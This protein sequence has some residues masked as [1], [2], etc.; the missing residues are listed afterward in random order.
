MLIIDTHCDSID[1]VKD[2][3]GCIANPYNMSAE[4]IQFAAMFTDRPGLAPEESWRLLT[5]MRQDLHRQ[6]QRWPEKLAFC[7]TLGEADAAV[8]AGKKALFFSMEGAA[9]LDGRPERLDEVTADGLR[10]VA[11]TWNQNNRYG[12]ANPFSGTPEDTG[13]T[14][15]GI[16]LVK[17]L[18]RRGILTDVSHASDNTCLDILRYSTLPVLATHSDFR[19]VTDHKR[20]LTDEQAKAIRDTGGVIG[21]NLCLAFLGDKG[22]DALLRHLEYGLR[23][24]GEDAIGF[25]FDI[26][27]IDDYPE[28]LDLSR[29]IHEQVVE[30]LHRAGYGEALIEKLACGNFRRVLAQI[31][32]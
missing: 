21:L 15:E 14:V 25:G 23:L 1:T 32:P 13:L 17:E 24:V 22:P 3:V 30:L 9:A 8:A 19:A 4:H 31:C 18:G 10:C 16:A 27:G 28:G 12:C 26:D 20:N 29:S 5:R 2:G 7:R 11:L 6:V